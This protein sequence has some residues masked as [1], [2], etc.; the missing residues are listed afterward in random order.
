MNDDQHQLER[1]QAA[2]AS[3]AASRRDFRR[4]PRRNSIM[5][6]PAHCQRWRWPSRDARRAA[7]AGWSSPGRTARDKQVDLPHALR[8]SPCTRL[9]ASNMISGAATVEMIAV[10]LTSMIAKLLDRRQHDP[11]GLRQDDVAHAPDRGHAERQRRLHLAAVDRLDPG[12]VDLADVGRAV[13]A[14]PD[15]RGLDRVELEADIRQAEIDDE[16]LD[17]RRRAAKTRYRR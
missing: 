14:E 11:D 8:T 17:Q 6:C 4:R 1:A 3:R 13:D 15:D 10:S 9:R 16:Q 5:P 2:S 12:T 7:T